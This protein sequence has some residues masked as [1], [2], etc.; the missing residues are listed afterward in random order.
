MTRLKQFSE[1]PTDSA[2][3][4]KKALSK[5]VVVMII[6][7]V[8]FLLRCFML[9]VKLVEVESDNATLGSHV[10]T[11]FGP[12]WW[13]VV[14]QTLVHSSLTL[15]IWQ[16]SDFIPRAV[17]TI[18]FFAFLR[19]GKRPAANSAAHESLQN[20]SQLSNKSTTRMYISP[21]YAPPSPTHKSFN[22][23]YKE[24]AASNEYEKQPSDESGDGSSSSFLEEHLLEPCSVISSVSDSSKSF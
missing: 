15:C 2:A 4:F 10:L 12:L 22:S 11:P 24:S 21:A 8:C 6:A 23:L 14:N 19:R 1:I 20:P 16:L 3:D 18:C 7:T 5:L 9:M 13:T 17:P